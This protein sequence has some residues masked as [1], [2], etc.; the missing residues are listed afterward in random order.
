MTVAAGGAGFWISFLLLL[1]FRP[2]LPLPL[3]FFLPLPLPSLF[4]VFL[5]SKAVILSA[6]G[7]F[8]VD[9][10]FHREIIHPHQEIH[11]KGVA[12]AYDWKHYVQL[13]LWG[14]DPEQADDWKVCAEMD[15]PNDL[16]SLYQITRAASWHHYGTVVLLPGKGSPSGIKALVVDSEEQDELVTE[17]YE[18]T[19]D[20]RGPGL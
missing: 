14:I 15:A 18:Q 11:R 3:R 17:A 10:P 6:Y 12:L 7:H 1:P 5:L 16:E 2:F 9:S 8:I 4:A 20:D 13:N 19:H